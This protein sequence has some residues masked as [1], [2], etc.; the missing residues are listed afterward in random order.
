[1][2]HDRVPFSAKEVS[3]DCQIALYTSIDYTFA[4]L[5]DCRPPRGRRRR[6]CRWWWH[7]LGQFTNKK[8]SSTATVGPIV[9]DDV[10]DPD[11]DN[12][13]I[14]LI[15]KKSMWFGLSVSIMK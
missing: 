14:T 3:R 2:N 13:D 9:L 12:E 15:K 10:P 8:Y 6:D 1:M 5:D 11:D 4:I 7:H